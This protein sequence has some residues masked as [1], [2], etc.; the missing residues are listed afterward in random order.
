MLQIK[1]SE[2]S[3]DAPLGIQ[4][5]NDVFHLLQVNQK[6]VKYLLFRIWRPYRSH[7]TQDCSGQEGSAHVADTVL[8]HADPL[9]T[10]TSQPGHT[11]KIKK[12]SNWQAASASNK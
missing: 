9:N 2:V 5:C 7:P 10:D 3:M 6:L 8:L 1:T 11:S 4:N 12:K